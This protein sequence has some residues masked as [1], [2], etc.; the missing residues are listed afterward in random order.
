MHADGGSHSEL[1]GNSAI[2]DRYLQLCEDREFAQAKQFLAP[3]A[4][5]QFPGK[6]EYRSLEEQ[7]ASPHT[8]YQWVRKR[9]LR[10]SEGTSGD[11]QTVVSMGELYGIDKQGKPFEGVRYVDYFVIR[12]GLIVEQLVWNDLAIDGVGRDR[13]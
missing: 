8:V 11:A 2:V 4:R 6:I 7:F 12:D 13:A 5:L 9:R 10:Y 1:T 3:N